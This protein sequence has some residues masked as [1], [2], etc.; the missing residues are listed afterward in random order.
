M[1]LLERLKGA[2]LEHPLAVNMLVF[3][4]IADICTTALWS[5]F[6]SFLDKLSLNTFLSVRSE[7]SAPFVNTLTAFD[8]YSGHNRDNFPQL[9]QIHLSKKPETF[10]QVFIIFLKFTSNFEYFFKKR[11]LRA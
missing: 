10:F 5:K 6:L 3:Q 7:I 1:S 2:L 4:N 8:K 9:I 11:S